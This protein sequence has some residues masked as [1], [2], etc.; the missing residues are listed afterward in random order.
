[1][2]LHTNIELFKDAV[3]A[4][5]Q[6]NGIQEIFI[7]KDYWVTLVLKTVFEDEIGKETIFKGG[8]AL[9]KCNSLIK[10]FSEDIDLVILRNPEETGKTSHLNPKSPP[11]PH[12]QPPPPNFKTTQKTNL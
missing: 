2:K 1:M 10:R 5:S 8:T 11:A 3:S 9:S 6:R 12:S 7:E 4:A